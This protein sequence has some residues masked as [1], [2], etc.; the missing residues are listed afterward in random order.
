MFA[1]LGLGGSKLSPTV[2]SKN[3]SKSS[4]LTS[5]KAS[6]VVNSFPTLDEPIAYDSNYFG[7]INKDGDE[8]EVALSSSDHETSVQSE[9][10]SSLPFAWDSKEDLGKEFVL[11]MISSG[12]NLDAFDQNN[13]TLLHYMVRKGDVE[14]V[15][16][17]LNNEANFNV[18]DSNGQTP[19][20]YAAEDGSDILVATLLD[21]GADLS[22]ADN[23]GWTPM[24]IAAERADN[25]IVNMF[26]EE[27]APLNL[28]DKKGWTPLHL[29]A[30]SSNLD[31]IKT[32]VFFG[33]DKNIRD[34]FGKTAYQWAKRNYEALEDTSE[35]DHAYLLK[36]Y[37]FLADKK[38]IMKGE[39]VG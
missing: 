12:A 18:Q 15:D 24:H 5:P 2:Q 8:T 4:P 9:S 14:I 29:A 17:L 3:A 32:L 21:I 37:Q 7:L 22:I 28:V 38:E 31:V 23:R 20:Y 1:S 11:D 36:I 27:K 26:C 34:T 10:E 35:A 6:L 16:L 39:A 30:K 13:Q 19:L 33:A 25:D